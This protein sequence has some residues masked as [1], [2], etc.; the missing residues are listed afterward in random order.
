M[1][2]DN[3]LLPVA[4][5]HHTSGVLTSQTPEAQSPYLDDRVQ[6]PSDAYSVLPPFFNLLPRGNLETRHLITT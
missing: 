4:P 6:P 5:G 2:T 1:I 3:P